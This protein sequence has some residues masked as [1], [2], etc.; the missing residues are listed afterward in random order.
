MRLHLPKQRRSW[1]AVSETQNA[2]RFL[3]ESGFCS[4]SV[5]AVCV[6]DQA[7]EQSGQGFEGM[8]GQPNWSF[9]SSCI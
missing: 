3:C 9:P 7:S 4:M 5:C 2:C 6:F 8:M 1:L